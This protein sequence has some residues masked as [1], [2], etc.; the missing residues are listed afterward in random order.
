MLE[1]QPEDSLIQT[2]KQVFGE[3]PLLTLR[4]YTEDLSLQI[5]QVIP[6]SF[7]WVKPLRVIKTFCQLF[8]TEEVRTVLNTILIEGYFSNK[9]FEA[10]LSAAFHACVAS[11]EHFIKF[12]ESFDPGNPNDSLVLSS[13]VSEIQSGND[14]EQKAQTLID[15]INYM[16]KQLVQEETTVMVEFIKKV[17]EIISESRKTVPENIINIRTVVSN[18][19]FDYIGALEQKRNLA[20][21]FLS[22]MKNYAII[23]VV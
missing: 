10:D 9:Q 2:I 5:Q 15:N 20:T 21:G 6:N 19:P 11:E 1:E 18:K 4:G 14:F 7:K 22:I 3:K 16:A 23:Q 13:Y 8:F 12:E 17:D